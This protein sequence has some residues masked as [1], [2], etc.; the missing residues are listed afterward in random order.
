MSAFGS[1]SLIPVDLA[2]PVIALFG[3]DVLLVG[4]CVV[5]A[6]AKRVKMTLEYWLLVFCV[7]VALGT[8]IATMA[9]WWIDS[10]Q[11][12]AQ[13]F[14]LRV[15]STFALVTLLVMLQMWIRAVHSQF[16]HGTPR[17]IRCVIFVLFGVVA[18]CFVFLLGSGIAFFVTLSEAAALADV[19]AFLVML[20]LTV[21]YGCAFLVYGIVLAVI[22]WRSQSASQRSQVHMVVPMAI[23]IFLGHMLVL[24][25]LARDAI[26][27]KV[28]LSC[29]YL[30]PLIV[31]G[32]YLVG[33][34]YSTGDLVFCRAVP[35]SFV[36]GERNAGSENA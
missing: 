35:V 27:F 34:C 18:V 15:T 14:C 21:V 26:G 20:G 30:S 1:P 11:S 3:L 9:L 31:A 36:C 8:R 29:V 7:L 25:Y 33:I 4:L 12:P 17:F 24:F 10:I 6:F 22:L 2:A 23:L 16:D 28:N 32:C 19:V 13:S 5:F